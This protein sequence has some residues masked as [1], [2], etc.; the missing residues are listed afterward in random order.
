MNNLVVLNA[1]QTR[2]TIGLTSHVQYYGYYVNEKREFIGLSDKDVDILF[3]TVRSEIA[4][5]INKEDKKK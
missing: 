5:K 3:K 2:F 4:S 1:E